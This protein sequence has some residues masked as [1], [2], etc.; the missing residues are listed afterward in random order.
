[1][2]DGSESTNVICL[3]EILRVLESW[4][5][6]GELSSINCYDKGMGRLTLTEQNSS[7]TQTYQQTLSLSI[8]IITDKNNQL[9]H[10]RSNTNKRNRRTCR[11]CAKLLQILCLNANLSFCSY[12]GQK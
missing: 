7:V 6:F 12:E 5:P 2:L 4:V 11:M 8:I 3:T 10:W 1:M 9:I